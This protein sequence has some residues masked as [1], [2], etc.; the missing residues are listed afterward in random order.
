[1]HAYPPSSW[2]SYRQSSGKQQTGKQQQPHSLIQSHKKGIMQ[3]KICCCSVHVL[4]VVLLSCQYYYFCF[5]TT[6][7][8]LLLSSSTRPLI[9][10][11]VWI[12]CKQQIIRVARIARQRMMMMMMILIIS[13]TTKIMPMMCVSAIITAAM[14]IMII[15]KNATMTQR[16]W[17]RNGIVNFKYRKENW[18]WP[19]PL[20]FPFCSVVVA[21][22]VVG[23][24]VHDFSVV[25]VDNDN[26]NDKTILISMG[27]EMMTLLQHNRPIHTQQVRQQA[28]AARCR[29]L[30]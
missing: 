23:M 15:I 20:S 5:T 17:L 2:I 13:A 19:V 21:L 12:A 1:M 3:W 4:H 14:G 11:H 25:L 8:F 9:R 22:P 24:A 30:L 6:T 7:P 26:D 29:Q 18:L 16:H 27:E 10:K 28:P